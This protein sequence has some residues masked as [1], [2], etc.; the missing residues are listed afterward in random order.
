[1]VIVGTS[2]ACNDGRSLRGIDKETDY[3]GTPESFRNC[4]SAA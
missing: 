2:G 3:A 4:D 1:V